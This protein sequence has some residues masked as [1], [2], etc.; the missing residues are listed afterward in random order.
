MDD[1]ERLGRWLRE[2]EKVEKISSNFMTK[3]KESLEHIDELLHQAKNN[4]GEARFID[5]NLYQWSDTHCFVT[6]LYNFS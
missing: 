1:E 6:R 2:V 5:L 3:Q 4:N